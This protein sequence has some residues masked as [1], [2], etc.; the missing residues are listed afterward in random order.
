MIEVEG[1]DGVVIEFPDG[2]DSETITKVMAQQFPAPQGG[3]SDSRNMAEEG[4]RKAEY[5]AR[6]FADSA[7]ETLGAVPDLV[8]K[9]TN[10]IG[11]TDLPEGYYTDTLKSGFK[12][13]GEALS[14]PINAV[15]PDAMNGPMTTAD[16]AVY[17]GGRGAADAASFMLP[18]MALAKTAKQGGTAARVGTELARQPVMQAVAG[19][20]GG[21]VGEATDSPYLGMAAALTAPLAA[22]A[23]G[24]V[25]SPVRNQLTAEQRRLADLAM[26]EG[27]KLTPAQRTGSKPLSY[28]ES[29]FKDMPLSSGPQTQIDDAQRAAFNRWALSKTGT[30]AN[31]ASPQ[32]LD[33]A[34]TRIGGAFDDLAA[35]TNVKID[36]TF[37]DDVD[38][39]AAEYG[40]RLP[41]DIKP[42]FQS[43]VDDLNQMRAAMGEAGADVTMVGKQ[44]QKVASDLRKAARGAKS[45][46]DLQD[47]LNGLV[48]AVDGAMI[49]S[50]TPDVAAGYKQARRDYRNLLAIDDAMA[51]GTAE[52]RTSGDIP[53]NALTSAVRRQDPRGFARGRGEMNDVARVGDFLANSTPPNSG[54]ATR[55]YITNMMTYGAPATGATAG[56]ITGDPVIA[57]GSVAASLLGPRVAQGAYNLGPVQRYLTNEAVKSPTLNRSV[58]ADILL[59]RSKD[60]LLS[61]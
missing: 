13:V 20:T 29:V 1:P 24:R 61:Q 15:A 52:S 41:T 18:G 22:S 25:I 56:Y 31:T 33:E 4:L 32:V 60:A 36:Q 37:F 6:G 10:A 35:K 38:R 34:F 26:K 53:F 7:M 45:N 58:I 2:T 46:N 11:L 55:N 5:G 16:K 19:A 28:I 57:A 30:P 9:G 51:K 3:A 48:D 43:Y 50:A 59:G 12:T 21:A 47:A 40:R 49:R 54:T 23:A 14:A 17:G 39:A 44:Y 42:V 8:A 27:I